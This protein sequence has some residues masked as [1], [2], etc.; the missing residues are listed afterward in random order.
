MLPESVLQ[1]SFIL[2]GGPGAGKTHVLKMCLALQH[3]FFPNTAQQCAFMNSAARLIAGRTLHSALNLPNGA[4]TASCRTLGKSKD[5]MLAV[6]R[7]ILLLCID[8]ISMVPA[9]TFSQSEYRARQVKQDERE[10]GSMTLLLT[11]DYL[12]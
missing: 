3:R 4:W 12:Q 6:W 9:D 1:H 10:W 8:E 5:T 2:L 7:R 11:G